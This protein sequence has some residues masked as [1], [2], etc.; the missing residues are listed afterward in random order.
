MYEN[1]AKNNLTASK[2]LSRFLPRVSNSVVSMETNWL[3][4]VYSNFENMLD[5]PTWHAGHEIHY[6]MSG[7]VD[8]TVGGK[9]LTVREKEFV[10]IPPKVIHSTDRIGEDTSKVVFS[11]N[12]ESKQDYF[13]DAMRHFDEVCV[14]RGSEHLEQLISMILSYAYESTPLAAEAISAL[15]VLLLFEFVGQAIPVE[16]ARS[17]KIEI[18]ESDRRINEI[19]AFIRENISDH[20]SAERVAEE[21]HLCLRHLNRITKKETGNTVSELINREKLRYIKR[22]LRSEMLLKDIAQQSGFSSEYTL[23]RFFK[24][25]EGLSLGAWRRS[26]EM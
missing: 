12:V 17:R 8:V 15:S 18:Y 9:Q 11:L 20:I 25:H 2:Q 13:A 26:S 4:V 1:N 19:F 16:E 23:N 14:Y 7:E 22:L 6:V 5:K 3:R 24:R 10:V 21:L